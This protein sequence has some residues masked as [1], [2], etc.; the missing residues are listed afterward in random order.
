MSREGTGEDSRRQILEVA[1]K[2]FF[3]KGYDNTT[4][5]DIVKGLGG[6]TKGAVYHHFKSKQDIFEQVMESFSRESENEVVE[7]D[8]GLDK[9]KALLVREF[10]EMEKQAIGYSGRVLLQT[11]RMIGEQYKAS[12][13]EGVPLI[14]AYIHE[15]I[16]DGSIKTEFPREV[17]E[18]LMVTFNLWMG[19]QMGTYSSEEAKR[20]L[21]FFQKIF[22]S[23]GIPILD[24]QVMNAAN[25]LI[26]YLKNY[27]RNLL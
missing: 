18:L 5:Q 24:E 11:P 16:E 27:Q 12:F 19:I 20:K 6:M 1:A 22:D 25:Q 21:V 23:M 26:D 4:I 3:E 8:T 15:G 7:G 13:D 9:I 10:L 14:E 2:L 17:A